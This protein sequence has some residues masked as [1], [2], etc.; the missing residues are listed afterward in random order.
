MEYVGASRAK[1]LVN[2]AIDEAD[3]IKKVAGNGESFR[4]PVV[5]KCSG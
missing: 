5:S 2:G 1:Q 4:R 3:A